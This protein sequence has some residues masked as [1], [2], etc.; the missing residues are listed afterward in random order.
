MLDQFI[1]WLLVVLILMQ[2]ERERSL[3]NSKLVEFQSLVQK[4]YAISS[5]ASISTQ[6]SVAGASPNTPTTIQ[7]GSPPSVS[8]FGQLGASLNTSRMLAIISNTNFSIVH[9][10]V[11]VRLTMYPLCHITSQVWCCI[12]LYLRAIPFLPE[13]QSG[14]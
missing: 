13:L 8:T 6:N 4:P 9:S 7:S 3:L 1:Y 2:I 11:Y 10:L 12:K 5:N 14:I